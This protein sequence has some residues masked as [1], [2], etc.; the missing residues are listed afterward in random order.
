[1]STA[2]RHSV[3]TDIF[4]IPFVL[5]NGPTADFKTLDLGGS[6]VSCTTS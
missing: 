2:G 1:L 5:L 6:S 3:L 4:C